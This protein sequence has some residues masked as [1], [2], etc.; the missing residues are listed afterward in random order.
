MIVAVSIVS[1]DGFNSLRRCLDDSCS[2]QWTTN[3]AERPSKLFTG[4]EKRLTIWLATKAG[5]DSKYQ[6]CI[7]NYQRWLTEERES[8]FD[9]TA[10]IVNP[11]TE[12]LVGD[13]LMKVVT[14]KEIGVLRKLG[15]QKPLKHFFSSSAQHAVIYTRKVRYFVQ[16]FDFVP[17]IEDGNGNALMPS[18]L[19]KLHF[20]SLL[21]RDAVIALLNSNL[22]FWFFNVFSDVR[23]VNRRE[24]EAFRFSLDSSQDEVLKEL[25]ILAKHLMVNLR[26]N[27]QLVTNVYSKHGTRI[28]QSFRPRLSKPIIDQIDNV[29]AKHYN[30]T[31]EELDFIINYDI[32]YRMG[33]NLWENA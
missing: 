6:S 31:D 4:V 14:L 24:I 32:K 28:I 19:K 18:E 17:S 13:A 29:L 10:Y 27:S 12:S 23:N 2:I 33:D 16:F 7:S 22:F 5:F 15:G 25:Q 26:K 20:E 11:L 21:Y 1:T 8:L 30:F 9:R 3:Y